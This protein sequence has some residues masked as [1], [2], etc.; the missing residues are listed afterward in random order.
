MIIERVRELRAADLDELLADSAATGWRHLARLWDDW[1]AASNRFDGRGEGLFLCRDRERAI[2]VCG[3]NVDP[4]A[5]DATVGRL[6]RLYVLRAYRRAGVGSRL[7]RHVL[8][9]AQA[10][11]REVRL[12]TD[13]P[14]AD[15]FYRA[16]GFTPAA[17]VEGC[18][19]IWQLHS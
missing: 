7:V 12:R 13:N 15:H 14:I 19:H 1:V 16:L 18:S 6:R 5:R 17:D 4:Y 11:F 3:I 10:S 9:E 8:D 2:G